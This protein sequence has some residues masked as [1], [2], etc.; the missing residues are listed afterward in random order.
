MPNGCNTVE[1]ILGKKCYGESRNY[2]KNSDETMQKDSI[3]DSAQ[4]GMQGYCL[5]DLTALHSTLV[6][7]LDDIL[8]ETS[9]LPDWITL[10]TTSAKELI[11]KRPC[12][13]QNY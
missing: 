8:N 1:R 11:P 3:I 7:E 10:E 5:K 13:G 6:K 4:K 9:P 12:K 2:R